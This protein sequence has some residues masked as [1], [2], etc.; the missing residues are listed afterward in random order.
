[1]QTRDNPGLPIT[2]AGCVSSVEDEKRCAGPLSDA[3]EQIKIFTL[4]LL[5]SIA[6]AGQDGDV[7]K[8]M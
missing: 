7:N 8:T 3:T 2:Y 1:M 6:P 4:V 5:I